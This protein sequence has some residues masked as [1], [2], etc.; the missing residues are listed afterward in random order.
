MPFEGRS[1]LLQ[2]I[3]DTHPVGHIEG[4]AGDQEK[5]L[6]EELSVRATILIVIMEVKDLQLIEL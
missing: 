5:L 4:K 6:G 1:V 2:E 3:T